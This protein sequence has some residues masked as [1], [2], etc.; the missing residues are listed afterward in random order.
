M[1]GQVIGHYK[2]ESIVKK[3]PYGTEYTASHHNDVKLKVNVIHVDSFV[4]SNKV[5]LSQMRSEWR[6]LMM[7]DHSSIRRHLD[8]YVQKEMVAIVTENLAGYTLRQLLQKR[9]IS[10]QRVIELG[11]RLLS[12][13]AYRHGNKIGNLLWTPDMIFICDDGR[14]KKFGYRRATSPR[15]STNQRPLLCFNAVCCPRIINGWKTCTSIRSLFFLI[16]SMG[17]V[18]W[19]KA[20][21]RNDLYGMMWWHTT[22]G[23]PDVRS[24]M[25]SQQVPPL[26]AKFILACTATNQ[27]MR[28]SN[29]Q[30]AFAA[31]QQ[32]I[33]PLLMKQ[34]QQVPIS[35]QTSTFG[36]AQ[37]GNA[38]SIPPVGVA[39]QENSN[40]MPKPLFGQQD[41][42]QLVS[43]K[44]SA[45]YSFSKHQSLSKK[46]H[47]NYTNRCKSCTA[48]FSGKRQNPAIKVMQSTPTMMTSVKQCPF[49]GLPI[50]N[51]LTHQKFRLENAVSRNPR[52]FLLV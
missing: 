7:L 41:A 23:A 25:E 27:G 50:H 3:L 14:V 42:H 51:Q 2:I 13:L 12:A 43:S 47:P 48:K 9:P 21:E 28:P 10:Y 26:L 31:W 40:G 17:N 4:L 16:D 37:F 52:F 22:V 34:E 30:V 36:H 29:A 33:S 32:S 11:E 45:K 49:T 6:K 35:Q 5:L 20:C 8:I 24:V 38:T 19:K 46:N 18:G 1:L 44:S 15:K 39:P